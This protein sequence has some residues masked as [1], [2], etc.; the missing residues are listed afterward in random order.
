MSG[1]AST[2]GVKATLSYWPSEPGIVCASVPDA[3]SQIFT[4]SPMH[5]ASSRSSG[6][7]APHM[8]YSLTGMILSWAPPM[9]HRVTP[10]EPATAIIDQSRAMARTP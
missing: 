8:L 6:E 3:M 10:F 1:A 2:S 7:M 5:V 9:P 4:A